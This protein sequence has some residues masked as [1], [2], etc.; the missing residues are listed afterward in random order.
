MQKIILLL[1]LLASVVLIS[2]CE[3]KKEKEK[4]IYF[5]LETVVKYDSKDNPIDTLEY[6]FRFYANN[7]REASIQ[8]YN[9]FFFNTDYLSELKFELSEDNLSYEPEGFRL[10]N[11]EL[12]VVNIDYSEI[13]DEVVDIWELM[14]RRAY[15]Y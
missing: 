4:N 9:R 13:K 7:D 5:Y 10:F 15:S 2:S 1:F 3:E 11:S 14:S 12:D 6:S 8:A